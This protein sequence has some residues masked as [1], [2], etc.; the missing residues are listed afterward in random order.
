MNACKHATYVQCEHT[1]VHRITS[2]RVAIKAI[3][4]SSDNPSGYYSEHKMNKLVRGH[5]NIVKLIDCIS[6]RVYS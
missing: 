6:V 5:T 3:K 4:S 1:G 2:E